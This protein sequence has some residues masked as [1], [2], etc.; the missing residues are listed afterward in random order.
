MAMDIKT[1]ENDIVFFIFF[2]FAEYKQP[3]AS[4]I[5]NCELAFILV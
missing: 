5:P 2:I 1:Y 3:L 4:T